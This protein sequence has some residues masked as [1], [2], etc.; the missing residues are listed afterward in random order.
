MRTTSAAW[1]DRSFWMTLLSRG[2][3][4]N[5][6]IDLPCQSWDRASTARALGSGIGDMNRGKWEFDTVA[7][8]STSGV[9]Q[10][11]KIR[12]TISG[13]RDHSVAI[14]WFGR[15]RWSAITFRQPGIY[16]ART[17]MFW[18]SNQR[19]SSTVNRNKVGKW[20]PPCLFIYET[21]VELSVAIIT[22]WP[23]STWAQCCR[24]WITAL[25]SKQLMWSLRSVWVHEP[26]I[27]ESPMWAPHPCM[28]AS[29]KIVNSAWNVRR[30][31]P[32]VRKRGSCQCSRRLARTRGSDRRSG[33]NRSVRPNEWK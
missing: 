15:D 9:P 7:K 28:E 25:S 10:T 1:V 12:L 5:M 16:L 33:V 14:G 2:K 23:W 8:M 26:E 11:L 3:R 13:C 27:W 30:G 4:G 22:W 29:V 6:Y 17:I 24:A 21:T 18:A 31:I 19:R 32:E 20:V